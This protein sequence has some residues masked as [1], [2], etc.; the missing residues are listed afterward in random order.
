MRK[1]IFL[2]AMFFAVMQ[3]DAQTWTTHTCNS[4]TTGSNT[5]G[6]MYSIPAAGAYN[7]T[8]V[9]LPKENLEPI[10]GKTFT[11]MHFKRLLAGNAMAGTPNFKIYI[12]E[13]SAY[14]WGTA[15]LDW[16]VETATATLVFDSNPAPI[17]GNTV[18]W[19]E[20]PLLS[21]YAYSGTQNLAVFMEYTNA[22]QSTTITWAYEYTDSCINPAN[23][24]STKYYNASGTVLPNLLTFETKNRPIFGFTFAQTCPAP[25]DVLFSNIT[26]LNATV[27]WTQTG[28]ATDWQYIIQPAG[29]SVPLQSASGN[30][31]TTNP[32]TTPATLTPETNYE[33]YI[34]TNCG[35]TEE[36]F[37]AGPY[38][39]Q[40]TCAA[41]STLPWN[42]NFDGLPSV[43]S[44]YFPSC[45]SK[46]IGDWATSIANSPVSSSPYSGTKYLR[47]QTNATND[48]MWTI[49]FDLTAGTSYDFS[50]FIQSNN[51][52]GW[53][54][55]YLVNTNQNS[56][57]ASQIG[58]T[59][60]PFGENINISTQGY[61]RV[62]STFVPTATGTYY[63]GVRVN[64]SSTVNGY[65]SF[66]D[67]ALE[68]TPTCVEPE[69]LT[70]SNVTA[71]SATLTWN[72]IGTATNW[73]IEY[74]AMGFTQGTGTTVQQNTTPSLA[75]T[76]GLLPNTLYDVYLKSDCGTESSTWLGPIRFKTPCAVINAP[77]FYNVD[78][79]A[80]TT[81]ADISDCWNTT[82]S[83]TTSSFRWN[84]YTINQTN[85]SANTGPFFAHSGY[86]YFFTEANSGTSGAVAEL[87]MPV[88]NIN[89]LT[90][91]TLQFFYHMF[92]SSMGEL[93]VDVY[94]G[95]TW[96]NDVFVKVGQQQTSE[97]DPWLLAIVDLSTY[98]GNIQVRFRGIRG[99]NFLGDMA[100]DDI[101][102][103]EAP[104]CFPPTNIV[105]SNITTS[106]VYIDWDVI[107][108]IFDFQY[109]IQA[110]GLGEPT[111]AGISVGDYGLTVNTGISPNTT[112][113]LYMRTECSTNSYS[114]WGAPVTFTTPCSAFTVPYSQNFDTTPAGSP[115]NITTPSCWTY[116]ETT[117]GSGYGYVGLSSTF[118]YSTPNVYILNNLSD[119]SGDYLLVSPETTNLSNGSNAITFYARGSV[120]G[121]SL[122]VGTMSDQNDADTFIALQTINLTNIY[123]Q[124][125]V[126]IPTGTNSYVAFRHG[127]SG[128]NRAIYIDDITVDQNLSAS[129]FDSTS[130]KVYPNPVT[131]V[132]NLDAVQNI[133]K[134]V[135][136][137]MLGQQVLVQVGNTTQTQLDMSALTAG[138]Y[139]VVVTAEGKSFPVRVIK[140]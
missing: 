92:G 55:D 130:F 21:P 64:Q 100:I 101:R 43:G 72:E 18:G 80:P 8:A 135:V 66:D 53:S 88:I 134:V 128:T 39:F 6:P 125:T 99:G 84:V 96:T 123:A 54:V 22:T 94:N 89:T 5:Y 91:P 58:T 32:F 133:E 56:L 41:I 116:T 106:S 90:S 57:G 31:A 108:S 62:K 11:S 112:Y 83:G 120:A 15:D 13:V 102:I 63:F 113:E 40:T 59:Y 7:R 4:T 136:Y 82:P 110:P 30:T 74:G 118:S 17:V 85:N 36:S 19:K 81:S 10:L 38:T 87:Y 115:N 124:Y 68:L 20:F 61:T 119:L 48:I 29:G 34:K 114:N 122:E 73:T 52:T 111:G 25:T 14:D 126:A 37:W 33:L 49:G 51:Q 121:Y 98:S 16:S 86:N 2:F 35:G 42:E 140:Q 9:I 70:F 1:I 78:N 47:T 26:P 69:G 137:N 60:I 44:T 50:S 79:A 23:N 107:P 71:T 109:V 24:N 127:L 75:I 46:E 132:L 105:V 12:K 3:M 139:N 77:Y 117:G 67:F 131:S 95:T 45:W 97:N 129:T 65:I 28:T 138:T 103:D 76:S 93:H 27:S 104:A